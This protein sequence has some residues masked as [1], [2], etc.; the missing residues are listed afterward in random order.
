MPVLLKALVMVF[1]VMMT[2]ERKIRRQEGSYM[3]RLTKGTHLFTN[4]CFN[5][6]YTISGE[7]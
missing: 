5:N 2:L 3:H 6:D 4:T 1:L 7:R